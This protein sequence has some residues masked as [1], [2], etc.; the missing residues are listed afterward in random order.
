M[1]FK[2][3]K[4]PWYIRYRYYLMA[5][6]AFLVF[7]IYVISLSLGPRTLRVEKD[8]IMIAEVVDG[9]FMEYVDVE[10]LVQPIL[11]IKVNTTESGSV[12]RIV[13]EEGS[14]LKQGDTIP[15]QREVYVLFIGEASRADSWSLYGAERHT[16]PL[17]SQVDDLCL[18][19]GVTTQSNTTHKSVPMILSS[20]HTSEH[21]ELYR[22]KGII[23]L[24]KEAGFDT[25]FISNQSPQGAMIDK[26][27]AEADTTQ[28]A[29]V[30]QTG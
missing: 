1:D 19:S 29:T 11:T 20:V 15:Q 27:A 16:N 3:E 8:N 23:A 7:L 25:Y 9:K 26:L 17:L 5:A 14:M 18:F 28:N 6:A 2:I 21:D 13:N 24:F 4:K 22:R 10:G 12:A 30:A